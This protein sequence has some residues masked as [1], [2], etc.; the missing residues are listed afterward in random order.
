[1]VYETVKSLRQAR[2]ERCS[3]LQ[4]KLPLLHIYLLRL[5]IVIV[6]ATFPVCGSGS[7]AIA[8]ATG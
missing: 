6:L 8:S 4:N 2:A 1:V 5:L 7:Q 3:A